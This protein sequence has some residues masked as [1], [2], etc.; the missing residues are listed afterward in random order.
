MNQVITDGLVLMPP[1]FASG[2][3]VWSR[4]DG[5]PGSD[6]WAS[7]ANAALVAADADFGSCLEIVKTEATTRLRHMGQTPIR[8]GLYLRVSARVKVLSGN[9]PSVR[10]AAWA[11][12]AASQNL[13]GVVQAGPT[14]ALTAYGAVIT[15]SAI[16]G[17]GTRTGVDMPWG[18]AASFAH[19]GL[20]LT[21]ANGGQVRID[22]IMVEDVTGVFLR[23]MMDWVDVRDYGAQGDGVSDDRAAFVAADAAAAGREIL[24]PAGNYLIGSSLTLN[25]PARFEGR[26]VMPDGAR[27]SLNRNFDLKGYAEA[28]G[29]DVLGLKKGIQQ[30]FNQSDH[31]GFDLCG[32]RVLLEAPL[33]IQAIVGN[34][35]TYANRRVLR[36]GQLAALN[37]PAWADEVVTRTGSWSASDPRR[38]TG[39]S[40]V[41]AIPVGALV[42][43]GQG[44]GREIYVTATDV[45]GGRITLSA[46]FYG[47]P[48][49]QSYTFRRFKYLLDFSGWL[50]LQRFVV[51][52]IEFLCAGVCS[53]L[54]LPRDGLVF[55]VQDCFFTGPKDRGITSTGE[56]CQGMQIDRC[57]FLSNEQDT[58]APL[59]TTI[60]FNTNSSDIKVRDNRVNKFRHFGVVG[61]TG[62]IFS[63]NHFFQGDG[64]TDGPRTA[65]LILT[66]NNTK[67]T[68]EGNY[69]DNCYVEWTNERDPTPAFTGGFSFHGLTLD[70][71]IFFSTESA[72][73]MNFITIKPYGPGHFING[74]TVTDNLFKK[75][76]GAQLSAVEG[77]DSSF[78]GL[79]LTRTADLVFKGNTYTGIVKRTENPVTL[80][81]AEGSASSVWNVDFTPFTPFGA[82]VRAATSFLA[83]GPL[84]SASNVIVYL[85]PYAEPAQGAGGRTLR[86]RWQQDVRG[87][88]QVTARCDL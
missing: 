45:A 80:R 24:V 69:V 29:D 9:L 21:G 57:Q 11:G 60:G 59:R 38:I 22:D 43:A 81:H 71:N 61:G 3:G 56:G 36:N 44:V 54:N 5:R 19:V 83:E 52:D 16:I 82:P 65:G 72:P 14:T 49:T 7:A 32:R 6:T 2:L 1:P 66:D 85:T 37:G 47:A 10:I 20:D 17:T 23:K 86:L 67:T 63:G 58:N 79:D 46:P 13:S 33:D 74:L 26:L 4:Q 51:S 28:M 35:N 8:P 68:F 34:R 25:S 87:T 30:L 77:V 76:G 12:N 84:R 48:V 78:A 88:A 41:A 39:L 40:N 70:G 75:T 53:A 31:E 64:V 62:N 18:P 15:V 55:Q 42:T 27:L 50:N 73:W